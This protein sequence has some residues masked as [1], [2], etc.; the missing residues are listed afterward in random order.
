MIRNSAKVEVAGTP[1]AWLGA[2]FWSRTGGPLMWRSYDPGVLREELAVLARHGLRQT[3]SFFYWPDF[4][5]EPDRLDEEKMAHFA[6]FLDAHVECGMQSIPTHIVGHMSG[7]N[8]DPSWRNGRDLY[9]DVWL[10]SR[11][12]WFVEQTTH[13]F[14]A[15]P[16]VAGWLISNEMPIYGRRFDEPTAPTEQVTAWAQ[17]MVSAVR[18]GGGTQPVSLGDGAWGIEVTGE[19]N[20][21]SV[22]E[23]GELVDFVGPHVYRMESDAVRQHLNAAFVCEL[24]AVARKPVVLEEFGLSSDFASAASSAAYYRQSLHNSLLAGATGWIAWNNTDYDHLFDQDPYRHHPFEMHF[25]ITTNDGTPKAPLLELADFA[26]TLADV[27][28]VHCR[29]DDVDA[30]LVVTS[31]LERQYPF[32]RPEDR[33]L[34]FRSL[35]QGYVAA[36]EASLPVGFA[37][38]EDGLVDDCRLYL[39]PSTRQLTAPTWHRLGDLARGGAVVYLSYCAGDS[40]F[41]RAGWFPRLDDLCGVEH[42]LDYGLNNPIDDDVV[43][44]T[45]TEQLGPIAEGEVL[46]VRAGGNQ[47][48]RAFL[49]VEPRAARVM[50]VDGHGRPAVLRNQVGDGEVVLSTYPLEHMASCLDRVNPEPTYRLYAAL[51][52][53]AGIRSPLV[54]DDPEVFTDTLVH[55]DGRRFAWLVSQSAQEKTVTPVVRDGRLLE[56]GTDAPV[57][58]VTLDGYGVRVLRLAG[59]DG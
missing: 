54:V 8:W 14:A 29:R 12:A 11:Q 19:D 56:L 57:E 30:A 51:A 20:G 18:A 25:G 22:R 50:A 43:E 45:F 52:E 9:A 1:V 46:R 49:P 17:L 27:D 35:R 7:E 16:A 53:L 10:V 2:N 4:M 3:R 39:L 33:T 58:K 15:H 31:Y 26:Q 36:R 34:I 41:Q 32:T 40:G 59:P 44:L 23:T 47:H 48:S 6:D 42:Q 55:D 38:E 13:R 37:R 28:F 21:Y 24:G 5:P